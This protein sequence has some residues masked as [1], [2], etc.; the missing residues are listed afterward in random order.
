MGT[1]IQ[2]TE[3]AEAS[4]LKKHVKIFAVITAIII[5]LGASLIYYFFEYKNH[6]IT[7]LFGLSVLGGGIT[8][9]FTLGGKYVMADKIP[10]KRNKIAC[11]K[12]GFTNLFLIVLTM[13]L[14]GGWGWWVTTGETARE[15]DILT[16]QP[17]AFTSAYVSYI[18]VTHSKSST[19]YDADIQYTV[20]GKIILQQTPDNTG[21]LKAGQTYRLKY[22]IPY[23]EMFVI[24]G[25]GN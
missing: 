8:L 6:R 13:A 5:I 17:T 21:Y 9:L 24:Y 12:Q 14:M 1:T 3:A 16:N 4:S 10:W 19:Y 22:S 7:Y 11:L 15:R 20:N 2:A 18:E 25:N 23:P